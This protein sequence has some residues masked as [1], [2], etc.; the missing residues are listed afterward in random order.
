MVQAMSE[1]G[2]Q[3][4]RPKGSGKVEKPRTHVLSVRFTHEQLQALRE[5]AAEDDRPA[6]WLA[7]RATVQFLQARGKLPPK[8]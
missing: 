1:P 3:R 7:N 2:K 8:P 5:V 6:A 4:G